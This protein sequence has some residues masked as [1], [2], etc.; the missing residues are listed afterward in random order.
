MGGIGWELGRSGYGGTVAPAWPGFPGRGEKLR[1]D[2]APV[3]CRPTGFLRS[4][5]DP[6]RALVPW[7]SRCLGGTPTALSG[8][9]NFTC[10]GC[11]F[12]GRER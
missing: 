12:P 1:K 4:S 8:R 3:G 6:A 2:G 7:L 11:S 10:G 9:R 5:D